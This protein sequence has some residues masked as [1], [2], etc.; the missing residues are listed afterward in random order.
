MACMKAVK[1]HYI[2]APGV[3]DRLCCS[4]LTAGHRG[5]HISCRFECDLLSSVELSWCG[6]S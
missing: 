2:E 4:L 3:L 6:V 1:E 5:A